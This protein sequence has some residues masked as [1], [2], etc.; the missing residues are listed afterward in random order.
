MFKAW[1]K[2]ALRGPTSWMRRLPDFI[3][4]GAQK[5][6][7]TSL[8]EY[9]AKHPC[10]K[11]PSEKELHYFSDAGHYRKGLTW[12]R[13]QF[14]L[15]WGAGRESFLT[16]EATPYYLFHPLTPQ[17]VFEALPLVKNIVM[18]RNPVDRAFSH[19]FHEVRENRETRSFEQ[20]IENEPAEMEREEAAMLRDGLYDG[21]KHRRCSYLSRG[22]YWAQLERWFKLFKRDQFVILKSEDYFMDP[23]RNFG[24]ILDFL[25]LPPRCIGTFKKIHEGVYDFPMRPDTR[26]RLR[27]FYKVHNERLSRLL[28][29]DFGWD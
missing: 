2:D 23:E 28:G 16:G 7:T 25:G 15:Q 10:I 17:R 14:P 26:E 19:Y 21:Y 24:L 13:S 5:A 12:Y 20:A 8:F 22:I 27:R 6:G 29:R 1:L 3:I 11:E 9:L 18:L 4:I